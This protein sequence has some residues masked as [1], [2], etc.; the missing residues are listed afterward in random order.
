MSHPRPRDTRPRHTARHVLSKQDDMGRWR[1]EE[2]LV[3]TDRLLI[4]MG[5]KGEQSKWVTFR[6]IRVIKRY[7]ET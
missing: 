3:N 1:T 5:E 7:V 6:A 4:P 2:N